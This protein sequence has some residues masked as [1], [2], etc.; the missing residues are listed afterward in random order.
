MVVTENRRD[1][2]SGQG[3]AEEDFILYQGKG[4]EVGMYERGSSKFPGQQTPLND[5]RSGSGKHK[6]RSH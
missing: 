1:V 4:G 3:G 2:S 5:S 6:S